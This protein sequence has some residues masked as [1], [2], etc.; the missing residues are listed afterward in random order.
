MSVSTSRNREKKLRRDGTE[1]K[2]D[3]KKDW[4]KKKIKEI[5]DVV[6]ELTDE[7]FEDLPES[8]KMTLKVLRK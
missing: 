5:T 6:H 7:E 3:T 1:K 4:T 8:L 2:R